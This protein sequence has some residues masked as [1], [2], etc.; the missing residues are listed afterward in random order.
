MGNIRYTKAEIA[1]KKSLAEAILKSKGK[2]MEDELG[3]MYDRVI[4]D[5][6]EYLKSKL[7]NQPRG[8]Q[9]GES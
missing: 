2:N 4:E 9:H 8:S 3:I 6:Y 5:N 7:T 1:K